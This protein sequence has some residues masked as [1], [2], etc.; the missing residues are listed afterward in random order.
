MTMV[1]AQDSAGELIAGRY[2][3]LDVALREEG[4]EI[5][6][7]E[8]TAFGRPVVLTR[9]N[10]AE[11]RG[12]E[13]REP[14]AD[15][16]LRAAEIL[17]PACPGL[18]A[19][20]LDVV[21]EPG[22]VWTVTER[23][24][25][26][27]L[28]ELLLRGPVAPV[29]ATHIGLGVLDVLTAAHGEGILHGEL[30][31]SQV[32]ADEQGTVTVTGFGLTAATGATRVTAPSYAS[33]EQ[34]RGEGGAPAADLWALG[35]I[36]YAL[37]EGRPAVR[38]RGQTEA[39]LRAVD[40]LPV[41]APRSAG[42]LAPAI[43]GL[44]RWDP[45]ERVPEAVVREAL[46][47]ILRQDLEES[48]PPEP[49]PDLLDPAGD[50]R[51]GGPAEERPGRTR[52]GLPVGRPALLGGALAVTVVA[53]AVFASMGGLP[54]GDNAS[55]SGSTPSQAASSTPSAAPTAAGSPPGRTPT[56]SAKPS[57][58]PSPSPTAGATLPAGFSTYQAAQGFSVALPLGWKPVETQ[59]SD[60]LAYRV[61]FGASG[62]PRTLAITY[63]TQL[64]PDPVAVWSDLEPSLR[65]VST[66]YERVGD[67]QPVTY[68]GM[69]G[70][71]MEW[72]SVSRGVRVRTFGRGFLIGGHRGFSLRWTTPANDW[73][74]TANRQAL[75]VFLNSFRPST[76]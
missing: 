31:P 37:V 51:D 68:R 41:R 33:P 29:R 32:W 46:T 26:V 15:R 18:V 23:P 75:D 11:H 62:D 22:F 70:A 17:G 40:R 61:T 24:P 66:G 3:L 35:A 57:S 2:R 59:S 72:Y 53:V 49:L 16:I 47:R 55:A 6:H 45:V 43:L 50:L 1:K 67:I 14:A 21:E 56:A 63:S 52:G 28:T 42:P 58:S 71:D 25:G 9:S 48:T 30:G 69:K 73:D 44:L 4:R 13:A 20:V 27:P 76:K 54:G 39:T 5:W 65:A 8:D 7:G 64:G 12:E 34:A 38:D 36:M 19:A 74:T 60:D 10:V